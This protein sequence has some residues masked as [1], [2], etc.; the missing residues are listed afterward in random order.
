MAKNSTHIT[1]NGN[2]YDAHSG[3]LIK[4]GKAAP[5]LTIDTVIGK[6][7]IPEIIPAPASA[8]GPAVSTTAK[9]LAV[10]RH[11][12][13]HLA[14][15]QPQAGK[16]LMRRAVLKPSASLKRQ[17]TVTSPLT[18]KPLAT[19]VA[20]PSV[21]SVDPR[22]ALHAETTAKH[23]MI[24][25]FN[26]ATTVRSAATPA[27][28]VH[29]PAAPAAAQPAAHQPSMDIFERALA[30]AESHKHKAPVLASDIK[31]RTRR[32]AL[33]VAMSSLAVVVIGGC[34]A[35]NNVANIKMQVASSRAGFHAVLPTKRPA[36]FSVGTLSATPGAV[37]V[38]F[39][40]NSDNRSFVVTQ[41]ASNW[42]SQ[43]LRDVFLSGSS[44]A[45]KYQ[46]VEAGGRTVY[47][48]GDNN[49]TWVNG[50]VWY[51]VKTDGTLSSRQLLD[52]ASSL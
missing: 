36:G 45:G 2:T 37:D 34:I 8:P 50:G 13:K 32:R 29:Q 9:Q 51:Q 48:Y 41:K 20:K 52:L 25:K 19:V 43:A 47:L 40:S 38:N 35:Y 3:E 5:A 23:A 11:P 16:T 15:H 7:Y 1:I 17:T 10:T 28:R 12:A 4:A 27:P 26:H 24:N 30:A 14:K 39:K 21:A 42:D 22:R 49:A 44:V 6:S 33:T 31:A 18:K 46:T